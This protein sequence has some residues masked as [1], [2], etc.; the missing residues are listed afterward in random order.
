M[1]FIHS[2]YSDELIKL[3]TVLKRLT[4]SEVADRPKPPPLC[5]KD[6]KRYLL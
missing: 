2:L 4:R 1:E 3:R 5:W 6:S